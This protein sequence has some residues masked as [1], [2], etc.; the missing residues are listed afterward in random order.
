M[1]WKTDGRPDFSHSYGFNDFHYLIKNTNNASM[2]SSLTEFDAGGHNLSMNVT[3]LSFSKY[4]RRLHPDL[5]LLLV[6]NIEQ[7]FCH[8]SG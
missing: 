4:F 8:L 6:Q 2:G 5:T 1:N 3:G 7:K